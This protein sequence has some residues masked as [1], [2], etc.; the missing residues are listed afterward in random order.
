MEYVGD[1]GVVGSMRRRPQLIWVYV[2]LSVM[3]PSAVADS[4]FRFVVLGAQLVFPGNCEIYV[5]PSVLDGKIRVNCKFGHEYHKD[6]STSF[7]RK[8]DTLSLDLHKEQYSS[9][10][11]TRKLN[12]KGNDGA[13]E[14]Y[15][16]AMLP[17]GGVEGDE[18]FGY[19]ICDDEMCM[20]TNYFSQ[21]LSEVSDLLSEISS[22]NLH[23]NHLRGLQ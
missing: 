8:Q 18:I 20:E 12:L 23:Q 21:G 15:F 16:L 3:L 4:S 14:H 19:T 5:R 2:L 9:S 6:F 13:L 1:V 22:L 17:P 7:T 11:L 10:T